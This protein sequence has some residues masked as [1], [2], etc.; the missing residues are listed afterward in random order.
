MKGGYG[1]R[2]NSNNYKSRKNRLRCDSIKTYFLVSSGVAQFCGCVCVYDLIRTVTN[3]NS[4][5]IG[6][7]QG[8][9]S[10]TTSLLITTKN[11]KVNMDRGDRGQKYKR[12]L[13][14]TVQISRALCV[15][16]SLYIDHRSV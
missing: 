13:I 4:N 15:T 7:D 2:P 12:G 3:S 10:I 8:S 9:N 1:V 5:L 11:Y 14:G 16:E 6:P